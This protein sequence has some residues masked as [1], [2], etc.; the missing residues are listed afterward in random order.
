[1]ETDRRACAGAR[2]CRRARCRDAC[3][4]GQ[5]PRQ[6]FCGDFLLS[7]ELC[8]VL[9]KMGTLVLCVVQQAMRTT[10]LRGTNVSELLL[11]TCCTHKPGRHRSW[12]LLGNVE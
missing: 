6:I 8:C 7:I 10:N 12:Q 3:A 11:K 4:T 5:G 1:M 2:E 9:N